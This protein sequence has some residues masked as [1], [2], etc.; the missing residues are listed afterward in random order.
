MIMQGTSNIDGT[1]NR[2]ANAMS[3]NNGD[4]VLYG[5]AEGDDLIGGDEADTLIGGT[6][7]DDFTEAQVRTSS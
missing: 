3:R 7:R 4:N 1:G 6:G 5:L 2:L